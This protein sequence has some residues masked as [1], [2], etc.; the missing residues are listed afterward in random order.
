MPER[1]RSPTFPPWASLPIPLNTNSVHH[2]RTYARIP[3]CTGPLCFRTT[4]PVL[5]PIRSSRIVICSIRPAPSSIETAVPFACPPPNR[6]HSRRRSDWSVCRSAARRCRPAR[7][8]RW[9][10]SGCRPI[11][12][13]SWEAAHHPP[14]PRLAP[15]MHGLHRVANHRAV[16]PILVGDLDGLPIAG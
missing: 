12:S 5:S 9:I 6:R 14:P 10:M 1:Y 4:L 3:L 7:W 16:L 13:L 2:D 11:R 15:S 8:P